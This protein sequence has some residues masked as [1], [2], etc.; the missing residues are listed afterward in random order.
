MSLYL[1]MRNLRRKWCGIEDELGRSWCR[2]A[3]GS[4]LCDVCR[5]ETQQHLS[6]LCLCKVTPSGEFSGK[7]LTPRHTAL[8]KFEW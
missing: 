3:G 6:H 1:L 2:I 5:G 8:S 4:M 7:S